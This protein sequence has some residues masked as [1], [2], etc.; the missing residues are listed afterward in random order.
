VKK[1]LK[2]EIISQFA[3][4]FNGLQIIS[5]IA[6][7]LAILSFVCRGEKK[8][9]IVNSLACIFCII[10]SLLVRPIQFSNFFLNFILIIVN[11]Y[12]L[13]KKD[14]KKIKVN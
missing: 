1:I 9:R 13:R 6:A 5:L 7:V 11:F 14:N 3:N 8:I 4:M 10:Y 12:H 2:Q